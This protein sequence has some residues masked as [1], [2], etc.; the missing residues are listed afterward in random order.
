MRYNNNYY[1]RSSRR[2]ILIVT[3]NVLRLHAS[4]QSATELGCRTLDLMLVLAAVATSLIYLQLLD[5]LLQSLRRRLTELHGLFLY[6]DSRCYRRCGENRF[7][8]LSCIRNKEGNHIPDCC[9]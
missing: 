9:L 8:I 2:T 1:E 4:E 3:C 6:R 5:G 7:G